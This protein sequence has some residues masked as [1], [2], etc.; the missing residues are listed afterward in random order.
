MKNGD[1]MT[2]TANNLRSGEVPS[3]KIET[4]NI[5]S[6]V[7]TPAAGANTVNIKANA[8]GEGKITFKVDYIDNKTGEPET[9]TVRLNVSVKNNIVLANRVTIS[10]TSLEMRKGETK[11]IYA[12]VGPRNV[13]FP[14]YTWSV[15]QGAVAGV[16]NTGL[17]TA[18]KTGGS[19]IIATSADGNATAWISVTVTE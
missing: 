2:I 10:P 5:I 13:T 16:N 14:G 11:Q 9:T 17:V 6:W 8:V 19:R 4:E 3:W 18:V 15:P 12:T 7:A 1:T